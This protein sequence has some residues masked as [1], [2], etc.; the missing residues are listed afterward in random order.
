VIDYKI[1]PI[2]EL[3]PDMA[4]CICTALQRGS[5][6]HA[7]NPDADEASILQSI[8]PLSVRD[9]PAGN[10]AISTHAFGFVSSYLTCV[11]VP[12]ALCNSG[13]RSQQCCLLSGFCS[14][15]I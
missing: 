14:C 3:A 4:D 9:D 12:G 5:S 6:F 15:S 13:G 7:A 8:L 1:V 11:L 2:Q 10:P